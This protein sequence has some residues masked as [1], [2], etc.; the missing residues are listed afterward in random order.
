MERQEKDLQSI[1]GQILKR[2]G[3]GSW[4]IHSRYRLTSTCCDWSA[5]WPLAPSTHRQPDDLP[6]L[7]PQ[8]VVHHRPCTYTDIC[9]SLSVFFLSL[10][11]SFPLS[12]YIQEQQS[13]PSSDLSVSP[14]RTDCPLVCDW[15]RTLARPGPWGSFWSGSCQSPRGRWLES[16]GQQCP[17]GEPPTGSV[18]PPTDSAALQNNPGFCRGA[19]RAG[20]MNDTGERSVSGT[21]DR[22][23]SEMDLHYLVNKSVNN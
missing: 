19:H 15:S 8:R 12:L 10:A 11:V 13:P 2:E 6:A 22:G 21:E 9:L 16:Q 7:R 17:G 3:G 4:W 18:W 20:L 1:L 14:F 23:H 5:C